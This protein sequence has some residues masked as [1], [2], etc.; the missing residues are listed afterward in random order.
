M[1][2]RVLA[3]VATILVW[4]GAAGVT[5]SVSN[6]A[7]TPSPAPAMATEESRDSEEVVADPVAM[8]RVIPVDLP[9]DSRIRTC[10]VPGELL[11]TDGASLTAAVNLVSTGE[12]L[13][14]RDGSALRSPASVV[15][16]LTAV[17]AWRVLG[18]DHRLETTVVRGGPGEVWL[19]GGGD[20]TLTRSPQSNYYDSTASLPELARATVEAVATRGE[21]VTVVHVDDSRYAEFPTWDDSWRTNAWALGYIAPVTSVQ[22]DGDRTIP[23]GR[24]SARSGDPVGRAANW[25]ADALATEGLPQR[26]S[27]AGLSS[28][29][30]GE[31]IARVSSAPIEDLIGIMLLDSDNTLA[32]VLAREVALAL[33]STTIGDALVSGAQ[34]PGLTS[35]DLVIHDGSGLSPLNQV[36]SGHVLAILH[37]ITSD[38]ELQEMVAHLPLAGETGS[39]QRRFLA[40]GS[41]AAGVVRAKTGSIAGV[42]SL[43]G[44][45]DLHE[46]Q[47]AFSINV[48]GPAVSDATRDRIDQLVAALYSCG[49]NL[50]H[51]LEEDAD[52]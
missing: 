46:D 8:A 40:A 51:W 18:P 25:F 37:A 36:S 17:A 47:L 4:A 52:S 21:T 13:L 7:Q 11:D 26:P 35:P 29:P 49:E 31:V 19:V 50:A 28:A 22:V 1:L 14:D 10:S 5:A 41:D 15:K 24:L 6:V 30:D 48:S 12:T 9:R 23:N 45:I 2:G 20:P 27:Y 38:S 33:Q 43:A 39:L 16:L 44:L 3:A 42:R 32:E 34:V